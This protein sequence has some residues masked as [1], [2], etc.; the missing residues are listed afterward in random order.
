MELGWRIRNFKLDLE[1]VSL[2]FLLNY[3]SECIGHE[4]I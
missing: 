1:M 2:G 3:K 4:F